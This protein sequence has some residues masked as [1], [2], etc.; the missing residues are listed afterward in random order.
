MKCVVPFPGGFKWSPRDPLRSSLWLQAISNPRNP[1]TSLMHH[2]SLLLHPHLHHLVLYWT[3][4]TLHPS[5]PHNRSNRSLVY[6]TTHPLN[7]RIRNLTKH[8]KIPS[9]TNCLVASCCVFLHSISHPHCHCLC[10]RP[11]DPSRLQGG[12]ACGFCFD[13]VVCYLVGNVCGLVEQVWEFMGWSYFRNVW[14]YRLELEVGF[15]FCSNG[16][17]G[18]RW[19]FKER[20]TFIFYYIYMYNSI[21]GFVL[22]WSIGRLRF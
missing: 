18:L 16:V 8:T 5:R 17:V 15:A 11:L 10:F 6:E 3:Y 19:Y 22:A 7:L 13:V 4:P 14:L 2:F 12:P 1:P 9:D 21:V 20:V